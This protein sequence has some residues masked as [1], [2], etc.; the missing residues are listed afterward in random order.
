M[1]VRVDQTFSRGLA[2]SQYNQRITMIRC[3]APYVCPYIV[4]G[5]PN[6]A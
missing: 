4:G 3:T 5:M 2:E 6:A 1:F